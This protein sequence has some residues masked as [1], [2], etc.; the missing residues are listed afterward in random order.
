MHLER[1]VVTVFLLW[2]LRRPRLIEFTYSM[3]ISTH[4]AT[5][6]MGTTARATSSSSPSV[7][8]RE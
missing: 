2:H 8:Q 7:I 6:T 5:A 1:A 4:A 3:W